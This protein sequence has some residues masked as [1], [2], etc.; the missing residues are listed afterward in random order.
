M[1]HVSARGG[2]SWLEGVA[3]G[4]WSVLQEGGAGGCGRWP[5][6]VGGRCGRREEVAGGGRRWPEGVAG[7]GWRVLPES[8]ARGCQRLPEVARGCQRL[9]VRVA[10]WRRVL[11]VTAGC[12]RKRWETM[13]DGISLQ[14][15]ADARRRGKTTQARAVHRYSLRMHKHD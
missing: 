3:E 14:L 5:G 7:G 12:S 4:C 10:G 6:G 2:G 13:S 1:L 8:V 15:N 9:P 11:P